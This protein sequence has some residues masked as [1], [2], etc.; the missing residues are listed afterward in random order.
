[1]SGQHVNRKDCDVPLPLSCG[2]ADEQFRGLRPRL[3]VLLDDHPSIHGSS[4]IWKRG[5]SSSLTSNAH[6]CRL[7]DACLKWCFLYEDTKKFK[8]GSVDMNYAMES[9]QNVSQSIATMMLF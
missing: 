6:R 2:L 8:T 5:I 3:A 1:L 7:N 9:Y 4:T